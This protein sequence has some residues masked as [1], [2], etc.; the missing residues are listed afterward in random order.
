[1]LILIMFI[2]NF[3]SHATYIS[4]LDFQIS[5]RVTLICGGFQIAGLCLVV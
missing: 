5:S 3:S 2:S 1:M 4:V